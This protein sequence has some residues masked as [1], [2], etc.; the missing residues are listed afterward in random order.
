ME[1]TIVELIDF[2]WSEQA[3]LKNRVHDVEVALSLEGSYVRII[4]FK[5]GVDTFKEGAEGWK[6]SSF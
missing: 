6:P 4:Q 3:G 1:P 2:G 5:G